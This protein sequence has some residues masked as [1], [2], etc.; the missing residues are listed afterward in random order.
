MHVCAHTQTHT[1][2]HTPQAHMLTYIQYRGTYKCMLHTHSTQAHT[3][4]HTHPGVKVNP[5]HMLETTTSY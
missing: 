3:N 5:L 4:A 1:E 2:R